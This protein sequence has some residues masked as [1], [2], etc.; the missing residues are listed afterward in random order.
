VSPTTITVP[1]P[2]IGDFDDVPVVEVLIAVGDTVAAEDSLVVLESEKATMEVPSPQAGKVAEVLVKVGDKVKEGVALVTLEVEGDG[3]D[4][5]TAGGSASAAGTSP[6]ASTP[7]T[8]SVASDVAAGEGPTAPAQRGADA[9]PVTS[10]SAEAEPGQ[11]AAREGVGVLEPV[12]LPDADH[13]AQVVVLGAGPGGYTAAFRA[14]DLGLDV[15]LIERY[16]RLG[17]VCLNV[18]CIPSKALLHTAKLITDA[19]ASGPHGVTFAAPEIDLDAVRE[20]KDAVVTKLVSGLSGMA[21]QRKV[22]VVH[23][24]ARFTGPHVLTLDPAGDDG[25]QTIAFEQCIIAAGSQS[26]DLPDLP[27]DPRIM[28]STAALELPD[29]PARL[30]IVG[31]GIIGLEMATVYDALG[32][33]VTVVE[34]ADVLMPGADQDLVKPLQK[35]IKG[36][37]AGVHVGTRVEAIAAED[38]ALHVR[39][40]GAGNPETTTFDRVIVAVGRRANGGALNAEA[41]G[42][43]V[44]TRGVIPVDARMRTN[45]PHISAIGDTV[46]GPMLAH[47]ALHEAKVAAEVIAGHDV[48]FDAR[49]IPSVAYTDPEVAWMGLTELEA[50]A[51]DIPY[52]VASFPWAASGRALAMDRSEGT[53]KLLVDPD[54]RRIL[55]AGAV[56]VHAGDLIAEAVLALEMGAVAGD[57]AL[58]VHP[59]PTL[60]ETIG[61]AA[62]LIEG[63]ITDLPQPRKQKR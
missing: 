31:G 33:S 57:V 62:D 50:K 16:E 45:V 51:Q 32:S 55:G 15:L 10:T 1:V 44:D 53:T 47:K 46:P 21:R 11:R 29:V 12:E 42:V 35:R 25:E 18:G 40:A 8:P 52:E 30:L 13:R 49:T 27:D 20:H 59:H 38:D 4:G 22:R 24:T 23:G 58:S 43:Q 39:F 28:D 61:L 7:S 2:D 19:E 6:S 26:V 54:T 63:T 9:T 5:A 56:G 17:G 3:G 60:S 36:R 48:V 34:L 41:A 14:A 37:Y